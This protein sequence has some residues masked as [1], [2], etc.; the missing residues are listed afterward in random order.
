MSL[1]QR[2]RERVVG[3]E[4][5]ARELYL[6]PESIAKRSALRLTK[7]SGVAFKL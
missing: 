2:D 1:H 7:A 5:D 3:G 6:I 4:I